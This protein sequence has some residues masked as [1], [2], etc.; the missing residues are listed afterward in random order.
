MQTGLGGLKSEEGEKA[1]KG[2]HRDRD[3]G[4]ERVSGESLEEGKYPI[5]TH[6]VKL[7]KN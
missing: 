7:S 5:Q 4:K 2:R 3:A 1:G 6:H